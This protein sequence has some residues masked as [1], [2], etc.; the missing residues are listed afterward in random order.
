MAESE[1]ERRHLELV[2]AALAAAMVQD[3]GNVGTGRAVRIYRQVLEELRR[4]G[5]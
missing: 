2:A 3:E 1:E 5:A 4:T